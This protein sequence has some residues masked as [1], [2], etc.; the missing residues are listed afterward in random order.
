MQC[1]ALDPSP[2][3]QNHL[4]C[5]GSTFKSC[6]ANKSCAKPLFCHPPIQ[7]DRR[8]QGQARARPR[9]G[10]RGLCKPQP[11]PPR[12]KLFKSFQHNSLLLQV[13]KVCWKRPGQ[14]LNPLLPPH[15]WSRAPRCSHPETQPTERAFVQLS[16]GPSVRAKS[17]VEAARATAPFPAQLSPS[18]SQQGTAPGWAA[19]GDSTAGPEGPKRGS[20][21]PCPTW[22]APSTP[23]GPSLPMPR[24]CGRARSRTH[25]T[26][27]APRYR[28]YGTSRGYRVPLGEGTSLK[29]RSR[30]SRPS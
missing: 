6:S 13:S 18:G 17:A 26:V 19:H 14:S 3:T 9:A 15:S 28:G 20:T 16:E 2:F 10:I 22:V 21:G 25:P 7:Q 27:L 1:Q 5:L 12:C 24:R 29:F 4:L 23:P 11:C 8:C 30:S